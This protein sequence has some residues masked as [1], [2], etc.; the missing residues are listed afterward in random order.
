[1]SNEDV[2]VSNRNSVCAVVCGVGVDGLKLVNGSHITERTSHTNDTRT[3]PSTS[4]AVDHQVSHDQL[5]KL[6][7]DC[8]QHG[9]SYQDRSPG[10]VGSSGRASTKVLDSSGGD[11]SY[12]GGSRTTWTTSRAQDGPLQDAFTAAGG[13]DEHCLSQEGRPGGFHERVQ[14][15]ALPQRHHQDHAAKDSDGP[16]RQVNSMWS[17]PS[18]VRDACLPELRGVPPE[19]SPIRDMGSV[20]VS[21][22]SVRSKTGSLCSMVGT[23]GASQDERGVDKSIHPSGSTDREGLCQGAQDQEGRTFNDLRRIV[24]WERDQF[25]VAPDH[26]DDQGPCRGSDIPEGGDQGAEGFTR[27][28]PEGSPR[29]Q[30]SS[31]HRELREGR[32]PEQAMRSS[33]TSEEVSDSALLQEPGVV[34]QP[35]SQPLSSGH[36]LSKTGSRQVVYQTD[37]MLPEALAELCQNDRT[38]LVEVACSQGSVLTSTMQKITGREGSSKRLSIWNHYDLTTGAGVKST[39]DVIDQTEPSHVWLSPDCGP[40]SP[41]QNINQRSDEQIESLKEK[42]KYALKQY[43]GCAV[44]YHYCIQRGIHVTWELS[45]SCQAWRLPI[46]QNLIHRFNLKTVIV[47]GC[48]VNLRAPNNHF[49]SKGWKL[50]STHPLI[51]SRM[52]LPCRCGSHVKHE[53]CEGSLTKKTALYTPEFAVR[54]C[55]A[56]LHDTDRKGCE[57]E[58]QGIRNECPG[59]GEGS[60]CSCEVGSQHEANLKC[61]HCSQGLKEA[62]EEP[63]N[64]PEE[65]PSALVSFKTPLGSSS[66][67]VEQVRKKLYLLHSATGHGP[68][69]H[70]VRA[71]R[72]R[73]APPWVIKEAENFRC[74]VCQEKSRPIPRNLASLEPQPRKLTTVSADVGHWHHP[75]TKEKFQFLLFVD[76]GSRFRVVGRMILHGKKQHMSAALFLSTFKEAWVSYF[77]HPQTLRVDPDG[78]L[79]SHEVSEYCDQQHIFLDI[80]AGEAHWKIGICERSIQTVKHLLEQVVQEHPDTTGEDALAECLRVMNMRE[81]HRG[82]SPMQHVMGKA[83]DETGRFFSGVQQDCPLLVSD[84][85]RAELQRTFALTS[86]S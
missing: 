37:R 8:D 44:I 76:E 5:G 61:G 74:S 75:I 64:N 73:G 2:D 65:G 68:I 42:R 59:F 18:R 52:D 63:P 9:E 78:A 6:P 79:R 77:G 54:V 1:M 69:K 13:Q 35:V 10:G 7:S 51:L 82:Y 86:N 45:Q 62:M 22:G 49:I 39:L 83:P 20:H 60:I 53:P 84:E 80:I 17:G 28:S 56:I 32:A 70:L 33:M 25:P 21:G 29:G 67:S 43:V 23:A 36:K 85:P 81:V 40:Y 71:L 46:I 19:G 16:L 34:P 30:E 48:Q 66:M 58:L 50:M 12:G 26:R 4:A 38:I 3:P 27:T 57:Q 55:E 31:I 47:R 14:C 24:C 15:G 72:I 11:C 41:M